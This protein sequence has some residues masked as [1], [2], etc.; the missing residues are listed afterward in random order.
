MGQ[1]KTPASWPGAS[2]APSERI[3]IDTNYPRILTGYFGRRCDQGTLGGQLGDLTLPNQRLPL[4]FGFR[5][6]HPG[7][8]YNAASRLKARISRAK[9]LASYVLTAP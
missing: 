8:S 1:R 9:P 4:V 3:P 7:L 6:A 5:C 2:D